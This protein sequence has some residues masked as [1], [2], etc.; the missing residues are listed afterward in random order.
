M[1]ES[2][3]NGN[4]LTGLSE[5]SFL[6]DN[7]GF[8]R[9]VY[10]GQENLLRIRF[11]ISLVLLKDLHLPAETTTR[12]QVIHVILRLIAARAAHPNDVRLLTEALLSLHGSVAERV[13][14]DVYHVSY[15]IPKYSEHWVTQ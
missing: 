7:A 14:S 3:Y 1:I 2:T 6:W 13:L 12:A 10:N 9:E 8:G 15:L 4:V 11:R 5:S